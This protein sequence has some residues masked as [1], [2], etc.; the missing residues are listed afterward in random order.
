M[1]GA[2]M[3][4]VASSL[5]LESSHLRAGEP[6]VIS[7]ITKA[8]LDVTMSASVPGIITAF[9]FKEGDFVQA[10]QPIVALDKRLEELEVERRQLLLETRRADYEGTVKLFQNTKGTSKE[11]MEKKESDHKLAVVEH[12]MALE[13]LQRRQLLAPVSGTIVE[14]NLDLGESCQPYQPLVRVVDTRQCYFLANIEAKVAATLKMDQKVKLE[15]ETGGEV[16]PV[17]GV[18]VFL[19]PVADAASG[20]IKLKVLFPNPGGRIRPGLAGSLPLK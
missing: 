13:Q 15:I 14:L 3:T 1:L 16:E 20:L 11:E 4:G 7:G 10:G 19:S 2:I 6:P 17:T 12:A 18:I 8:Y 5:L 9:H